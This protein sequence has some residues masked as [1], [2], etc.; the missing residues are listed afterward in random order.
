MMFG[1]VLV[2]G[3]CFGGGRRQDQGTGGMAPSG[4][5]PGDWKPTADYARRQDISVATVLTIEG[6]DYTNGDDYVK[7]WSNMFNVKT[8]VI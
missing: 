5:F 7:F 8:D 1:L 6:Y 2:T 4:K 3:L